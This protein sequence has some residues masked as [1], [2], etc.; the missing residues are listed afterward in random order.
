MRIV[1]NY[2]DNFAYDIA[3]DVIRRGELK[4]VDVINQSIEMILSTNY[5][6]R[7]FNPNFGSILANYMFENLNEQTG[8][9][10][11]DDIIREILKWE[12]RI[13]II[14]R[15]VSLILEPEENSLILKIPYIIKRNQLKSTFEKKIIF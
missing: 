8:E 12:D 9:R 5:G 4:D 1:K 11:L 13:Q 2:R 15:D 3:R 6:D 7:L 14:D 10:L